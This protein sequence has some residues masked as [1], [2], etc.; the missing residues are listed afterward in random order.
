MPHVRTRPDVVA[1]GASSD[2]VSDSAPFIVVAW[3]DPV[4]DAIAKT[5]L[6][7]ALGYADGHDLME[8]V[9]EEAGLSRRAKPAISL[10]K[11][12]AVAAL[13]EARFMAVCGRGDCKAEVAAGDDLRV[14]VAAATP[15]DCEICHGSSNAKAVEDLVAAFRGAG[16]QR[17]CIVGGSPN[18]HTELARLVAG[19]IEL[20]LVDGTGMRSAAQAKADLAWADRVA[21][22]GATLLGHRVSQL[23]RG[24]HVIQL[25]RRSVRDL[26]R[27][28]AASVQ[29]AEAGRRGFRS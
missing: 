18:T 29:P 2:L 14:A 25:A 23:Y 13:L 1:V 16:L 10:A 26:A 12:E 6:F 27:E 9:L 15:A 24:E 17:L 20:R 22:W 8:M 5:D 21:I 7:I 19:R 3:R 11:R 28:V 4:A